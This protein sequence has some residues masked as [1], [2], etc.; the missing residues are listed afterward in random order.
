MSTFDPVFDAMLCRLGSR[1]NLDDPDLDALRAIPYKLRTLDPSAYIVREG[2][3]PERCSLVISG[4]A[5][6]QK[7]TASGTRQ[8]VAIQIPGDFID[9]Q[10][11]F[12]KVSDHNVQALTRLTFADFPIPALQKLVLERPTIA[13]AMWVDAL[14]DAS[15][16]R[17]WVVNVG[18]RDA[19]TRVAHVLCEFAVRLG[20]SGVDQ[21]HAYDLPMTQEQLADATGLT[22]VHV[23]RVLKSL[24]KD[25]LVQR[26]RRQI[27]ILNWSAL[28]EAADFNDRYLHLEQT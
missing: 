15:I 11:L 22:P 7:L 2:A 27:K 5:Y 6:R 26:D 25:N 12:L 1:W 10:N 24:N 17:E 14:I 3:R 16:F 20:A 4:F 8:I 19:R 18:R 28:R 21:S 9:L 23:N 13:R